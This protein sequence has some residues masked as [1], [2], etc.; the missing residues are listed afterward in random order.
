MSHLIEY[1]KELEKCINCYNANTG[2]FLCI[3]NSVHEAARCLN[4]EATNICKVLLNKHKRCKDYYFTYFDK[5]LQ[6]NEVILNSGK[7]PIYE[8]DENGNVIKLYP[9]ATVCGKELG[10]DR[11][12]IVAVCRGR[13][14]T[15]KGHYF[16]YANK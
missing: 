15:A 16:K 5:K 12:S 6:P 2:E 13:K 9:D 1:N 10:V 11:S 8:I 3:F 14:L 4:I 7:N